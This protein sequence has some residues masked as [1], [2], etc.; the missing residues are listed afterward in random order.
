MLLGV[1]AHNRFFPDVSLVLI[2]IVLAVLVAARQYL[3]QRE[4]AAAEAARRESSPTPAG[5][6]LVSLLEKHSPKNESA[7]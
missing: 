5:Q 2:V 7:N 1:E 6:R 3:A 4:L